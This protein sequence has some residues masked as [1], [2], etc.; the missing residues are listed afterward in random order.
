MSEEKDDLVER[1]RE[2]KGAEGNVGF[3]WSTLEE[4]AD[5]IEKLEY[6]KNFWRSQTKLWS[7]RYDNNWWQGR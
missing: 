4:A 3:P 7:E 6:E 1:L 5:R 2:G